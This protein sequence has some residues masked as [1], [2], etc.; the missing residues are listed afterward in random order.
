MYFTKI[1]GTGNDFIMIDCLKSCNNDNKLQKYAAKLC[2]RHFGIGGDGIILMLPPDKEENDYKM[3]IFNTDGSEAEMCG[4]GIRCFT[5]YLTTNNLTEKKQLNIE[6]RAGIIKPKV[7]KN[8]KYFS[9]IEVN[10]GKPDFTPE[11]IPI[12]INNLT[13]DFI[14]D[15]KIK[16]DSQTFK[17]NCVSMGN[18]HTVIFVKDF[19]N[20]KLKKWG[21]KIEHMKIFP[22]KTNV[23]FIRIINREKIEM[24]VWERGSGITLA[25]GTGACASVIAG[26]KK[27]LLNNKVKVLLPG[28]KLWIEWSGQKNDPV[29]MTGPAAI[30][31]EGKISSNSFLN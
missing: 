14:E 21:R 15:F 2:D 5:H 31:F 23:E 9:M 27:E 16:F 10:M 24:K 12:K 4:N 19:S 18:P 22:E 28:G 3:R 20:L 11:N 8:R 13:D 25:C 7:L 6:T 1:Q 17:I 26:I 30:V 29:K